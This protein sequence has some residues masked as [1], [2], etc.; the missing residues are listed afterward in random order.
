MAELTIEIVT[1]TGVLYSG[2]C[3]SC[4]APGA[5]GQFQ[6]LEG[7]AALMA[8]LEIGEM[9]IEDSG[10]EKHLATSGGFLEVKDNFIAIVAESAEFADK[11]DIERAKE[12]EKRARERLEKSEEHD[13]D[14]QRAQLAL[15]RAINRIKISSRHL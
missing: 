5:E 4:T 3:T 14:V 12:A 13:I 10:K 15:A 6:I 2:S 1:P 8:N 9:R 7:H 11:I